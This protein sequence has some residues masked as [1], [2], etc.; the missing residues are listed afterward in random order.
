MGA[1]NAL[2]DITFSRDILNNAFPLVRNASLHLSLKTYPSQAVCENLVCRRYDERC[3][4]EIPAAE[5]TRC[6]EGKVFFSLSFFP[7]MLNTILN[8]NVIFNH[9]AQLVNYANQHANHRLTE[10]I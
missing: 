1:G 5:G 2:G 3:F 8:V 4:V 6:G 7:L 10:I 9:C